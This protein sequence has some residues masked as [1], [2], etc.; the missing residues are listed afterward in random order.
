MREMRK[1]CLKVEFGAKNNINLKELGVFGKDFSEVKK[2]F[3]KIV[4]CGRYV[5]AKSKTRHPWL[6][7][8]YV[9]LATATL[10]HYKGKT[11]IGQN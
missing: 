4:I 9:W 11:K 3:S 2:K 8:S 7:M 5:H 10:W 6:K 1:F